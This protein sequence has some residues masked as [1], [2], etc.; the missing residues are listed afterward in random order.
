MIFKK[1]FLNCTD[2]SRVSLT[3]ILLLLREI[4][5]LSQQA[6][7]RCLLACLYSMRRRCFTSFKGN[8][9]FLSINLASEWRISS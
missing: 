5:H 1:V 8:P 4:P 7:D 3:D 9:H 6:D 2:V